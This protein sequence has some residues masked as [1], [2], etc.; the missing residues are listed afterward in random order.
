MSSIDW[1]CSESTIRPILAISD[2]DPSSTSVASFCRSVTISSTVIEP[3]I[4]RRCP[5]KIRPVSVDIWSWSDRNRC[6]ALTMLSSS[7]PT[8]NAI[9]ART[10]SEIPCLVTH[11]SATSASFI[12]RVRK[13]VLRKNGSTNAPWPV[14]TLNG[15]PPRPNLPPEISIASS[16]AGTRY[17]SIFHL[18][19]SYPKGPREQAWP[20]LPVLLHKWFIGE[21]V[22]RIGPLADINGPGPPRFDDQD[23]RSLGQRGERPGQVGLRAAADLDD[24]FP[25]SGLAPRGHAEHADRAD[26]RG[27][28]SQCQPL[29]MPPRIPEPSGYAAGR[30]SAVGQ[31]RQE[32]TAGSAAV[33]SISTSWPG[34]PSCATPSRVLAVVS[35]PAIGEFRSAV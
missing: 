26:K 7:L 4:E 9:T 34:K 20:A 8:L 12:D 25:G 16:G 21:G 2:L 11:V 17:P 3:M 33:T 30:A 22:Q 5:A 14:M 13:L 32:V 35:A 27:L 1:I 28:S 10:F 24:H 31:V 15:A 23:F 18:Q 29:L 6:P 19:L